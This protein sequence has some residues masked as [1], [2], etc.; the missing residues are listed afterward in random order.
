MKTVNKFP[1]YKKKNDN[2]LLGARLIKIIKRGE[3]DNLSSHTAS[4]DD[5]L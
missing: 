3:L 2:I 4:A 1:W 5:V